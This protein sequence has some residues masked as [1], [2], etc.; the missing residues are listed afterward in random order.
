M[1]HLCTHR[2][3]RDEY[4]WICQ[5]GF[6]PIQLVRNICGK[7]PSTRNSQVGVAP[8]KVTLLEKEARWKMGWLDHTGDWL[9]LS[10]QKTLEVP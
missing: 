9:D 10:K 4:F 7:F 3:Q 8:V 6:P 5:L 1:L 2:V